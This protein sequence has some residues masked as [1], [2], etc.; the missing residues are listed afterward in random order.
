MTTLRNEHTQGGAVMLLVLCG[1]SSGLVV[2][3]IWS[4]FR[5]L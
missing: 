5:S 2:G 1:L 3:I 4:L